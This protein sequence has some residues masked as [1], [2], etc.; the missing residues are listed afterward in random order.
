MTERLD[1]RAD[2]VFKELAASGRYLNTGKVLIGVAY[3]PRAREMSYGEE[4][5]QGALLGDR[6]PRYRPLDAAY[7]ALLAILF[8]TLFISCTS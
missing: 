3:V 2:K 7:A 1:Q 5:L 8:A 6:G 4:R